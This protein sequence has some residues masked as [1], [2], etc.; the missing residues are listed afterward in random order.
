MD[1]LNYNNG[2]PDDP[3]AQVCKYNSACAQYIILE[4]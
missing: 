4:L 3:I 1:G 2:I